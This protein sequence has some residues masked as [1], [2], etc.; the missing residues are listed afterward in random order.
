MEVPS[1]GIPRVVLCT[2]TGFGGSRVSRPLAF[3]ADEAAEP[4]AP[5]TGDNV[6]RRRPCEP[7]RC[8]GAPARRTSE[9]GEGTQQS[10][11]TCGVA[12]AEMRN[13]GGRV[14]E[15]GFKG[16]GVDQSHQIA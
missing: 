6:I 1:V 3:D 13:G 4:E 12:V 11:S 9:G 10:V 7:T 14:G 15:L 16:D 2:T 8:G 5:P